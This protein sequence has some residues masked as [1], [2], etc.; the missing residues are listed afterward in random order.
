MLFPRSNDT[1]KHFRGQTDTFG[2]ILEM[3]GLQAVLIANSQDPSVDSGD[4]KRLH[5]V[6]GQGRSAVSEFMQSSQSDF[7]AVSFG[8]SLC[9]AE[10]QGVAEAKQGIDWVCRRSAVAAREGPR[11][12]KELGEKLVPESGGLSFKATKGVQRGH[13]G[14]H[15]QNGLELFDKFAGNRKPL[16]LIMPGGLH[17]GFN[18]GLDNEAGQFQSSGWMG[19]NAMLYHPQSGGAGIVADE[20]SATLVTCWRKPNDVNAMLKKQLY[21]LIGGPDVAVAVNGTQSVEVKAQGST[22]ARGESQ[23]TVDN[24]KFAWSDHM[25]NRGLHVGDVLRHDGRLL[26]KESED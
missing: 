11:G 17:L 10:E 13:A 7:Q 26:G 3:L 6:T 4:A 15:S 20:A 2:G 16:A 9:A 1:R 12:N 19:Q 21:R 5:K 18:F 25:G 23:A 14:Q 8:S 24:P 22:V